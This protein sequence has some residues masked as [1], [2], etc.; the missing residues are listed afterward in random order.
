MRPSRLRLLSS[1]TCHAGQRDADGAGCACAAPQPS[2]GTATAACSR[3][4]RCRSA[5]FAI[6]HQ[7]RDRQRQVALPG[8]EGI[9]QVELERVRREVAAALQGTGGAQHEVVTQPALHRTVQAVAGAGA[10]AVAGV[11]ARLIQL[12]GPGNG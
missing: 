3:R 8:F 10:L 4:R 1:S 5:E 6:G 11:Q 2:N 7:R 9:A 12:P